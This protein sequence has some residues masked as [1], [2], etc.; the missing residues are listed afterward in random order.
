MDTAFMFMYAIGSFFSGQLGDRSIAQY[1]E[2]FLTRTL[3]Y[4]C[5]YH[6]PTVIGFGLIASALCVTLLT[7][8]SAPLISTSET[9]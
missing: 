4:L 6:A 5:R 9:Q 3:Y 8:V 1:K 2:L 7:A